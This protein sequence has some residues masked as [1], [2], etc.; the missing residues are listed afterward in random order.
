MLMQYLYSRLWHRASSAEK[1][2]TGLEGSWV[3][4][5]YGEGPEAT[6]N[7]G[8]I[9]KA[10][11]SVSRGIWSMVVNMHSKYFQ[12]GVVCVGQKETTG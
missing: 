2:R 9:E 7:D 4:R 3:K 1:A 6:R 8:P 12:E 11:S 10:A 5:A